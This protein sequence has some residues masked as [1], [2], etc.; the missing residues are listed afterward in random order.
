MARRP[1][2]RIGIGQQVQIDLVR[3]YGATVTFAEDPGSPVISTALQEGD[4]LAWLSSESKH[5]IPI[6]R[7]D[8]GFT[9]AG[10]DVELPAK[11]LFTRLY[12]LASLQDVPTLG[13]NMLRARLPGYQETEVRFDATPIEFGLS[14]SI[15]HLKRTTDGF[16]SLNLQ[17]KASPGRLGEALASRP[18][19][20]ALVL[21]SSDGR[22]DWFPCRLSVDGAEELDGVPFGSYSAAIQLKN[23][24]K[25]QAES[26]TV[27][28]EHV[29]LLVDLTV[30]GGAELMLE[31]ADGSPAGGGFR[32]AITDDVP[33]PSDR[34]LYEARNASAMTAD[35]FPYLV[36]PLAT[37]TYTLIPMNH[38][39]ASG[40]ANGHVSFAIRPGEISPIKLTLK[41]G[42]EA[43]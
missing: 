43:K 22:E 24:T 27:D 15:V 19:E 18:I 16:G 31:Y 32:F 4:I 35:R 9:L 11:G 29:P 39:V 6:L 20:C 40:D 8:V 41:V 3:V 1:K 42:P 34:G 38:R 23:G 5:A 7:D 10:G 33:Q 30:H 13:P 2:R 21:T 28:G 12:L 36:A 37:G 25:L 14:N 17:A 26:V